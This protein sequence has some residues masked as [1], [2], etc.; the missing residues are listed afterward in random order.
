LKANNNIRDVE[1][2]IAMNAGALIQAGKIDIADSQRFLD[3]DIP[4]LAKEFFELHNLVEKSPLEDYYE[5]IDDYSERLLIQRF[6]VNEPKPNR[7]V[8]YNLWHVELAVIE[9]NT[10]WEEVVKKAATFRD[11]GGKE[12]YELV[13]HLKKEG[14]NVKE[15]PVDVIDYNNL[16]D[17][18]LEIE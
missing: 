3:Y 11:N 10:G 18:L 5:L 2:G 17:Y 8:L 4:L 15:L 12:V 6:G 1:L 16:D 7:I 13:A 9:I 14:Y